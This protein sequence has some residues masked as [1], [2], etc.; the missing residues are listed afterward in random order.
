MKTQKFKFKV[1]DKV[2]HKPDLYGMTESTITKIEKK[3]KSST[4]LLSLESD[5]QSTRKELNARI[6]IINEIEYF[7]H[8]G[9]SKCNLNPRKSQF[10]GYVVHTKNKKMNT[11]WCNPE[12]TLNIKKIKPPIKRNPKKYYLLKGLKGKPSYE[13]INLR[14]SWN[15]LTNEQVDNLIKEKELQLHKKGEDFEIYY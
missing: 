9:D 8:D 1:G 13:V 12:K 2:S 7:V 11:V 6:E 15:E 10:C 5:I 3:Y 4:G 14:P